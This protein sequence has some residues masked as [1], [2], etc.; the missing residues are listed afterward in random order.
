MKAAAAGLGAFLI[1]CGGGGSNADPYV[2]TNPSGPPQ[3]TPTATNAV[4][5]SDN[6]FSPAAIQVA[7]GATVRWTWVAD[8]RE[9]NVRFADG[10][11]SEILTANGSYSRHF[12]TAGTY[13]YQCMLHSGMNGTVTV[14]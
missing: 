3:T 12:P 8:S 4:S 13:N 14:K 2:I 10:T 9:H 6:L 11:G 7:P 1:G 5:V